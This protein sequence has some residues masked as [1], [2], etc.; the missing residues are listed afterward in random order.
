LKKYGLS[1]KDRIKSKRD[2]EIIY[3]SGKSVLSFDKKIKANY[4]IKPVEH[5]PGVRMAVAVAKKLGNAVWRN[6]LKR[7]LRESIRLNKTDLVNICYNEQKSVWI[8]FS[9]NMLNQKKYK[10]LK[11][12]DIT[13][14]VSN[15]IEKIAGLI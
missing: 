5:Q 9:S 3:H 10:K 11:L 15:I 7:L 4:I 13:P 1:A 6:K 14:G 12:D 8:I 2:L